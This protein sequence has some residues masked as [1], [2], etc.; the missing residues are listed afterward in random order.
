MADLS[1]QHSSSVSVTYINVIQKKR[2]CK[3]TVIRTSALPK[4]LNNSRTVIEN[5]CRS[6]RT[7]PWAH[8]LCT[9]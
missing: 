6:L 8:I 9:S 2:R 5:Q 3:D 4:A 1:L 7:N